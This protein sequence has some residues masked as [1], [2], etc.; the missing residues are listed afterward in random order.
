MNYFDKFAVLFREDTII[1]K[2]AAYPL[3]QASTDIL[4]LSADLLDDLRAKVEAFNAAK[5]RMFAETCGDTIHAAQRKLNDVFD[6]VRGF[7]PYRDLKIDWFSAYNLFPL[8]YEE[9]HEN[10]EASMTD[11]TPARQDMLEFLRKISEL[12]ERLEGFRKQVGLVLEL[13]FEEL[14]KRNSSAYAS[15]YAKY[16]QDMVAGGA[17]LFHDINADIEFEQSFPAELKFVP[18]VIKDQED[19]PIIAEETQFGELHM[20]LFTDF[21][22]GLM[23]GNAP[24]RCH[25]CGRFF[26][27]TRGYNTCYCNNIAPGET[28][29]TCRQVGA[30]RVAARL[31]SGDTPL[32]KEYAKAINR[33]KGQRNSGKI[34]RTDFTVFEDE[35]KSLVNQVEQGQIADV[36]A[37]RKI[38]QISRFRNRK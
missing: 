26:L 11:G 4:N 19:V 28:E 2:T 8:L 36:E 12:P 32:L 25:N 5:E 23:H 34:S 18:I 17:L 29:R 38:H 33:I 37:I 20:F 30:H 3:G 1:T 21:Y 7:P 24:R 14:K 31:W 6:I 10:W 9:N 22:R 13:Y 27:L 35:A 16:Y 15:A